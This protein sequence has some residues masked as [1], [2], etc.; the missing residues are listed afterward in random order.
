MV[1]AVYYLH[2]SIDTRLLQYN[3]KRCSSHGPKWLLSLVF[4][5]SVMDQKQKDF[6]LVMK[7]T[8]VLIIITDFS[9]S[10][11]RPLRGLSLTGR[12]RCK[13]ET[14]ISQST[15]INPSQPKNVVSK[16]SWKSVQG[17]RQGSF[18][19]EYILNPT[20]FDRYLSSPT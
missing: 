1:F 11:L 6:N 18:R 12:S 4:Q 8:M 13:L 14:S 3:S 10:G 15:E 16:L 17:L 5:S 7:S 2:T 9:K 19:K 20:P